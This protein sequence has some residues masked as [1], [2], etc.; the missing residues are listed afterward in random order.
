MSDG[1]VVATGENWDDQC[2]V[3]DWSDIIA[4]SAGEVH[5]V[6]LKSD[7]TVV[8]TDISSFADG[9]WGQCE[10]SDWLENDLRFD[11]DAISMLH[12]NLLKQLAPLSHKHTTL[13][14]IIRFIEH[15]Q[16]L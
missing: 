8:A 4:I 1:T 7:G 11:M 2:E 6:G 5:T 13:E 10:V 15:E 3:D 14:T 16:S 9:N 12:I